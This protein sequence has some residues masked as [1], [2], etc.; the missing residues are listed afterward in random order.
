MNKS[1]AVRIARDFGQIRESRPL[2][3]SMTNFV[4]MNETAN[5]LLAVGASPVMSDAIE[6]VEE[7]VGISA[8]LVLNIGTLYPDSVESMIKAGQAANARGI[9]VVLDPV[10]AGATSLRTASARKILSSVNVSLLRAN[11]GEAMALAGM[12]S[13]VHGVDSEEAIEH[14]AG[15]AA[16]I[17]SRIGCPVAVTGR[18]DVICDNKTTLLCR[19]GHSMLQSVTGTGCTVSALAGAFLAVNRDVCVAAAGALGVFGL[20]GELAANGARGPGTFEIALRDWLY[21]I[22]AGQIVDGVLVESA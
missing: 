21:S 17:S 19:N 2:V 7:M 15:V 10:G 16:E 3:H 4:V 6:E 18:V 14:F 13:R 5:A 9:P 22:N 11:Q 1:I 20:C 12:E 8:A